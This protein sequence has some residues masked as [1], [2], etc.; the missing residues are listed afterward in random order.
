[1]FIRTRPH[2]PLTE[3]LVANEGLRADHEVKV[4]DLAA[5]EPDYGALLEE[6]FAPDSA[7]V[8]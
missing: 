7:Q 2:D 5:G 6:I 3:M 8:V 1:M 4:I